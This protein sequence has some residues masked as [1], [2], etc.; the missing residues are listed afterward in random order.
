MI[1]FIVSLSSSEYLRNRCHCEAK[2][3]QLVNLYTMMM[4]MKSPKKPPSL[5]PSAEQ[6][7][8]VDL[9]GEGD[10]AVGVDP[11]LAHRLQHQRRHEQPRRLL[12]E[13]QRQVQ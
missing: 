3:N 10:G 11:E 2:M 12:F 5:T 9:V 13:A 6:S 1:L 8:G 4:M 7:L